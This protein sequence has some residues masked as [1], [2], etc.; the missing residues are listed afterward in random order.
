MRLVIFDSDLILN[1]NKYIIEFLQNKTFERFVI[2]TEG[3]NLL[4]Y[5]IIK[6]FLTQK[7]GS[8]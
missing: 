2:S 4:I 6:R 3:R 1:L 8:K 7:T 5:A